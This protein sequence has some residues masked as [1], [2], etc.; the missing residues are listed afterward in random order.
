MASWDDVSRLAAG[1]PGVE[2]TDGQWG[3]G[4][5]SIA[6]ERPLR[7]KDLEALGADAPDGPIL[8][9]RTD[10]VAGK[11]ALLADDPDVYF[12]TPHF[13]GY[14]AVLVRLDRIGEDALRELLTEAW[15]LRVPKKVGNAYLEANGIA[16]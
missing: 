10:G 11:E 9:A 3:V 2:E 15:L 6:W 4:G 1:L 5:K 14:P 8:C 13:N 16:G 7:P 12:T